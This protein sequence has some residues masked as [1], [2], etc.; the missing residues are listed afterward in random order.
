MRKVADLL[1]AMPTNS[2]RAN[3]GT[4]ADFTVETCPKKVANEFLFCCLLEYQ[5]DERRAWNNGYRFIHENLQDPDDLWAVIANYSED[6]WKSK[7]KEFGLHWL[8][9]AHNRLW[10]IGRDIC[11]TYQGDARKIWSGRGCSDVLGRLLHLNAGKQISRMIVGALFD[12]KQIKSAGNV[13]ADVHVCRVLGRVVYGRETSDDAALLLADQMNPANPWQL[14]WPLWKV[15]NSLCR[16]TSPDC[17][18]CN[19]ASYCTYV[20]EHPLTN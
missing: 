10:R 18:K 20:R 5:I 11:S 1:L 13:K 3:W 2:P 15:G 16:P 7:Y 9:N 4:I 6:E 14:D 12:C 19:L 17:I 8:H